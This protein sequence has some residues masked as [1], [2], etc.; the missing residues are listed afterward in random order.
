MKKLLQFGETH[1]LGHGAPIYI[2]RLG[3]EP[4]AT[5]P[6]DAELALRKANRA[7][8]RR[9]RKRRFMVELLADVL[10]EIREERAA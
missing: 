3:G 9:L 2:K 4:A 8:R 1:D 10:A 7:Y 5:D 6:V